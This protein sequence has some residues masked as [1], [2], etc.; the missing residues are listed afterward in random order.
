MYRSLKRGNAR[1]SWQDSPGGD[2]HDDVRRR[3][4]PR[5]FYRG[6]KTVLAFW[7]YLRH[8]ETLPRTGARTWLQRQPALDM[9]DAGWPDSH[10]L[11]D[12]FRQVRILAARPSSRHRS[13]YK[14][15]QDINAVLYSLKG[16][17]NSWAIV[18]KM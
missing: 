5:Q 9:L 13:Y 2:D 6:E 17:D 14:G 3:T 4:L 7:G 8:S 12:D 1:V 16:S 15:K 10:E 11:D 18:D